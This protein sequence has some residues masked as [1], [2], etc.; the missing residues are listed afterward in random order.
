MRLKVE[1]YILSLWVLF[2]LLFINKAEAPLCFSFDCQ[3]IGFKALITTNWIPTFCVLGMLAGCISY[4]RFKHRILKASKGAPGTVTVVEHISFENL[5]FL[6]TYIIPLLCFDL[7]FHLDEG[8]NAIMLILVLVAIGAIYIKADLY[9]TNP[10]LAL[11]NFKIYRIEYTTAGANA[12][13]L[14]AHKVIAL[15]RD[16]LRVGSV[17]VTKSIG[18]EGDVELVRIK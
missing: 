17:I 7:D 9:Y 5:S 2:L 8:R 16:R 6:A 11:M 15:S 14:V 18:D 13:D 1:L 10:S 3:F 4:W 12:G